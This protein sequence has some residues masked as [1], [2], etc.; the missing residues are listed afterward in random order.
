MS[1]SPASTSSST[2]GAPSAP[3]IDTAPAGPRPGRRAVRI[4]LV[5]IVLALA[6]MWVYALFFASKEAVYKVNDPVWRD[7]AEEVCTRYEE[8]RLALTD[9]G[10]GYIAE[11][12]QEQMIARAD[13]VDTATD[14]LEQMIAEV[15]ATVPATARDQELVTRYAG[16]YATMIADRRAYTARLRSFELGPYRETKVEGGP[17]TNLLVDFATVNELPHCSPPQE[18]GGDS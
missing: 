11:P 15:T 17:V 8:Q 6:T 9:T 16:F 10:Q 7:H 14:L 1:T 13:V 3:G 2:N 4:V 12:T 18:L 5:V